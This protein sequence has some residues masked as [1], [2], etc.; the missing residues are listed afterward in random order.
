[1]KTIR[2]Y[3]WPL[4]KV[5]YEVIYNYIHQHTMTIK[6]EIPHQE[7]NPAPLSMRLLP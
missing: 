6:I 7:W 4:L 5:T 1:M 2:S 3:S